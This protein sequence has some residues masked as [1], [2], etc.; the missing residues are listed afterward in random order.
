MNLSVSLRMSVAKEDSTDQD[1]VEGLLGCFREEG[2]FLEDQLDQGQQGTHLFAS[3]QF[4]NTFTAL[5]KF[6][7]YRRNQNKP[8][9]WNNPLNRHLKINLNGEHLL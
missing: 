2:E 3:E 5:F 9:N 8:K 7:R 6:L 4:H 1:I